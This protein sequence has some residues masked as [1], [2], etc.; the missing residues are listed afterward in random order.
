MLTAQVQGVPAFPNLGKFKEALAS[1]AKGAELAESVLAS[2][3]ARADALLLASEIEQDR[4]IV[5]DTLHDW[6]ETLLHARRSVAYLDRLSKVPG[7]S[8]DQNRAAA[9][10]SINIG[11]GLMNIHRY[12]E[13]VLQIGRAIELGRHSGAPSSVIA[14][15]LSVLANAR[16]QAGDL[17]GALSAITEARALGEKAQYPKQIRRASAL[18]AILWRQGVILGEDE[19]VSLNRPADAVE[20]LQ[21]AFD[22]VDQ[23]A[24]QDPNE[25][26]FRD[27]VGTAGQQLAD[28]LR[29][30]DP[31]RALAIYDRTL[32]R[33][34]EINGGNKTPAASKPACWPIPLTRCEAL[35]RFPQA[36]QRIDQAFD[37]LRP[38][39]KTFPR[40]ASSEANGITPCAP[41]PT[42]NPPPAIPI[43]PGPSCSIFKPNCWPC[44]PTRKPICA[45]PTTCRGSTIRSPRLTRAWASMPRPAKSRLSEP[46]CGSFGIVSCPP[47]HISS[48]K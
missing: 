11:Q 17:D 25:V 34:R 43:A 36:K 16:R 30:S 29:H 46:I 9:R 35:R 32:L 2:A 37:I 27:R 4:M 39:A 47:T 8:V 21:K 24:A 6:P 19:S 33:L 41:R 3:P 10:I 38:W 18:Y 5:T 28:I 20:P 40:S 26:S 14:Q 31:A 44:V 45:T 48:A 15:G 22:L 13:A 42:R 7:V 23:M 1:L 12:Q